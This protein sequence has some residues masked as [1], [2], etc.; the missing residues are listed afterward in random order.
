MTRQIV[1]LRGINL[2]P[3]RRI[4]MPALREL[5]GRAG[6][7][8]V[9]TYVQSGNVVLS[10]EL[11]A[12]ELADLCEREIAA[13]FGFEVKVVVRS[14]DELAEV[15]RRNPLQAVA[16]DPKRYQVTFL[17]TELG[18]AALDRLDG[19]EVAPEQV[20]VVGRELYSWHPAGVG[21]SRL[22]ARLAGEGWLG[23]N[24]TARNWT[25]VSTLLSLAD[26]G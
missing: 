11:G 2:G 16:V 19:L 22:W 21:R 14:R 5:L 15:V 12:E 7:H 4:G 24:A 23:V 9:R 3:R 13:H 10:S 25:T 20:V 26:E 6:L 8:D 17:A 1:L 18:P